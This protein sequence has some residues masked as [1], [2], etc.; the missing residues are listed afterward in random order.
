MHSNS[1]KLQHPSNTDL[2]FNSIS[3]K[4]KEKFFVDAAGHNL[5]IKSQDQEK[6]FKKAEAFLK[7]F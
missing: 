5:F 2:V 3:S 1:D 6:I 4:I 7:K